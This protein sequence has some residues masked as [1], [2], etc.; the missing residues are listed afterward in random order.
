VPSEFVK[1]A[2][3]KQSPV[4][5]VTI[6]HCVDLKLESAFSRDYFKIPD[7][8]FT[9]LAMFDTHSIAERKNPYGAIKAFKI[10][11]AGSD[12]SICLVLKVNNSEAADMNK[13]I[14]S[15]QSHPNILIMAESHSRQ[16]INALLSLSDCFVSLHRSEGFGLGPAEAMCLGKA[17]ILTNWSGSTDYMTADNCKAIDFELLKIRKTLGPYQAGQRWAE[18]DLEQ[19]AAAMRELASYPELARSIGNSARQTIRQLFSPAAVGKKIAARLEI[20]RQL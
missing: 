8:A 9:F 1:R 12:N 16:E 11:F 14:E 7:A 10:A 6:P 15:I 13:L 19:A 5:V 2:M 18:P 3:E 17:T 20:I 4:P